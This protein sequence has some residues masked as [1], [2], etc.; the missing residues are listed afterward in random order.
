MFLLGRNK[1]RA[2]EMVWWVRAP[3]AKAGLGLIARTHMVEG[4]NFLLQ[5]A[6]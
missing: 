5:V 4:K 3:A 1:V 2:G 6:L